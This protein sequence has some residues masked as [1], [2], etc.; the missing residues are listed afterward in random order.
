MEAKHEDHDR[1]EPH[2]EV[3]INV[4]NKP[5]VVPRDTTGAEIKKRAGIDPSW[6]LF[7]V[8]GDHEIKVENDTPVHATPYEKFI[9]TPTLDPS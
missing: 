6:Q 8:R 7:V 9:A 2:G 1:H 5:V 3:E 4:N